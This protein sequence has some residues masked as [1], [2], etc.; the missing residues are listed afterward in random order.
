MELNLTAD[1]HLLGPIWADTIDNLKGTFF[2]SNWDIYALCVSIGM[3]Y[4]QQ[5][6]SE[7]MV[8]EGYNTEPRYI[9]RNMLGHPQNIS[10]LEFM[11][12]TAL[13]TTKHIDMDEDD[14]L[15][16]AFDKTKKGDFKPIPFLTKY[17]NFGVTK[18]HELISDSDDIET[19]EALMTFLN[20]TY[21]DGANNLEDSAEID[22]LE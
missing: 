10:L 16:L 5:I 9:P 7:A 11:L 1:I 4:D 20:S 6:E 12:Q 13:V 14:R 2:E 21:E 3:M 18:I 19:M 22:S 15:Q 8:P 17:A